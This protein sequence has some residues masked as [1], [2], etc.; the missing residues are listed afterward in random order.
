MNTQLRLPAELWGSTI[1]HLLPPRSTVEQASFLFV[2]PSNA[3]AFEVIASVNLGPGDFRSQCRDYLELADATR[4]D[5][6]RRAHQFD[7]S[8]VEMHSHPFPMPAAF[9]PADIVGL[10]E[11][12]P[13]M[14]WRLKARPYFAVVV[15]PNDFDALVWRAN[16]DEPEPLAAIFDGDTP[17][18]P[19]G[20]TLARW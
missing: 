19:T 18:S 11:T 6:I 13:H 7:A 3:D 8:L 5:I 20:I 4:A 16:P 10:S 9:S 17:M 15:G 14:W 2:R 12:V 1:S